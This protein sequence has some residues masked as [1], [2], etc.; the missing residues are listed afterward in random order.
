M[1]LEENRE[2]SPARRR[3]GA[4][5]LARRGIS[6]DVEQRSI[7]VNV[8]DEELAQRKAEW[9]QPEDRFSRGYGKLYFNETTQA[10]DGCDFRFLHHDGSVTPEPSIH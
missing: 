7:N 2:H 8:S 9:Q 4:D 5:D 10:H 1:I 3:G 6:L